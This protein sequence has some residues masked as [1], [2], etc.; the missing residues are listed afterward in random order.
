M[1][2]LVPGGMG[3]SETYARELLRELAVGP[4]DVRTL[5][6][7][8]AAGFSPGLPEQVA[9][10][11]RTGTSASLRARALLLAQLRR[12]RLA[13]RL[14]GTDVVHYPFT[15]PVPAAGRRRR[16]VVSLLDVQHHDLPELFSVAERMYRAVAY[17]RAARSADAVVTISEFCKQRILTR[18]GLSPAKVHVAPLG[19]R[20]DEFTPQLGDR[21]PMLLYPAKGWAHK[22]HLL[23]LTAF[24][25]LRARR[26][27]LR[28]VLTGAHRDE[29]PRSLPD[30]VEVRG[31]VPRAELVELYRRSA[32]LVFPSR[33]EG[34]GLPVL[35]AMASGCPVVAARAGS[36]PEVV[37]DAGVLVDPDDATSVADGVEAVLDEAGE[38]QRRGLARAQTFSWRACA[39]AH[40]EVYAGLGG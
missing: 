26:P 3:G 25:L 16:S 1:L 33:Y 27:E 32:A 13:A 18:L 9:A 14:T 20:F 31:L 24:E 2:T 19:V 17:D 35:E 5:V 23:L 39:A 40:E 15:V 12:R 38:W 36:L 4:L 10:E 6:A 34:F 7:P 37:G 21:E 22:N 29:L 28:L 30:G 8:V 11:Y